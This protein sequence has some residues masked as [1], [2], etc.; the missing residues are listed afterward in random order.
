[1]KWKIRTEGRYTPPEGFE[2]DD[3]LY[4]LLKIRGIDDNSIHSFLNPA[5][6]FLHSPFMFTHMEKAI[7]RIMDNIKTQKP[8]LLHGDYD[9]DGI[10]GVSLLY[11]VI[12][13]M[14]GKVYYYI[15]AR[16][17][18][19]YGL[20]KKGVDYAREIGANLIITVDCGISGVEEVDYANS[21]SIDVIVTDHHHPK[22]HV[23]DAFAII[24]PKLDERY[25]FKYLAG[26]GVA[27]KLALAL[28]YTHGLEQKEVLWL[29]DLVA[30]GTVADVVPMIGE[31]RIL[32]YHGLQVLNKTRNTGIR[33]LME[34]AGITPPVKTHHIGFILGPRINALGRLSHAGDGV[35]LLTTYDKNLA[36]EIA[37]RMDFYNK[38]RQS[39]EKSILEGALKK[40]EEMGIEDYSSI[41]LWDEEWHQG[42]I[43][44]VASRL[45]E[46]FHRPTIL[47][48]V[49]GEFSKGSGRSTPSIDLFETL[50]SLEDM[51]EEFGGHREAAGLVVKSDKL[52]E[53]RSA[54]NNVVKE[55]ISPE[56]LEGVVYIDMEISLDEVNEKTLAMI[57]SLEPFGPM[58]PSP[59][60]IIRDLKVVGYPENF[61]GEHIRFRVLKEREHREVLGFNGLKHL[62]NIKERPDVD[63]V[64]SVYK[65]RNGGTK[66]KL[67]DIRIKEGG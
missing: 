64:V 26:V 48:S 54:F 27:F 1:M 24:N 6:R 5:L 3:L 23:P 21:L 17:S 22:E 47:F 65:D 58:N 42:V 28:A 51:I 9:V 66:L 39:T 15:P 2:I 16:L 50:T 35:K 57:K 49:D 7:G 8:I 10:T 40:V 4:T 13:K 62:D 30:M 32:T 25:P 37:R 59:V 44:I 46:R 60:F 63:L 20:S 61:K 41:V 36:M 43:G 11:R 52:E 38:E 55:K 53:F 45:V 19:G 56:D 12:K 29:L 67:I 18:E 31:N 34:V 14:G 33:A